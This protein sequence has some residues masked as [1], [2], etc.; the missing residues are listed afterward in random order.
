MSTPSDA[1]NANQAIHH[2][3]QL[4]RFIWAPRSTH[5]DMH[6]VSQI[7]VLRKPATLGA[8]LLAYKTAEDENVEP[9]QKCR[10]EGYNL[11]TCQSRG[12][13]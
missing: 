3:P 12:F 1:R 7:G 10:P 9:L 11:P 13:G 4:E 5:G 8:T 2:E 6:D